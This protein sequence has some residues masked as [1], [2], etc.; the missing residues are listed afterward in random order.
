[1][2]RPAS[3]ALLGTWAIA[4]F[5]PLAPIAHAQTRAADLTTER[6]GSLYDQCLAISGAKASRANVA[7]EQI[8]SHARDE[9]AALRTSLLAGFDGAS[10][11]VIVFNM[12]DEGRAKS[13]L[14]TTRAQRDLRPR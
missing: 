8:Y 14:E 6:A 13:F 4:A 11:R 9:C 7:V 3:A 5:F 10:E 12:I 2:K 1:M